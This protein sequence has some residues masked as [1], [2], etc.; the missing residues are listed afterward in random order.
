MKT[1]T[2]DLKA[3][4]R[5]AYTVAALVCL[6]LA[7]PFI[8]HLIPRQ[9]SVPLGVVFL[10]IYYAPLIGVILF[11]KRAGILTA[12]LAP[13]INHLITGRPDGNMLI[14]LSLE[15]PVFVGIY[16]FMSDKAAAPGAGIKDTFRI[17]ASYVI[18]VLLC[19]AILGQAPHLIFKGNTVTLFLRSLFMSSPGILILCLLSRTL[20]KYKISHDRS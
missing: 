16:S 18:S 2:L 13:V 3:V 5:E 4:L 17:I 8:F 19:S 1:L 11:K 9:G 12:V 7:L 10:P 14:L 15:I 6:S 20:N